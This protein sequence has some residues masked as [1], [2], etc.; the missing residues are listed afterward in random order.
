MRE[1][2][3]EWKL[4]FIATWVGGLLAHAYRFFNF[5][6]T[7]DTLYS[8]LGTGST[9]HSGRWFLDWASRLSTDYELTWVI[10]VLSLLYISIA[11]I[12]IIELLEIKSKSAIVLTSVLIVTFPTVT[13]TF[14]Y[15]FTAD[16][17]MMAFMLAVAGVYLTEKY[18]YGFIPG[19]L[20]VCLSMSAYQAY[21]SVALVLA[22]VVCIKRVLMDGFTFVQAFLREYRQAVTLAGGAVLNLILT[23]VINAYLEI[24]LV[25]YQG[26]NDVHILTIEDNLKAVGTSWNSFKWFFLIGEWADES[27]YSRFNQLAVLLLLVFTVWFV[28]KNKVYKRPVALCCVV[29]AYLCMPMLMYIILFTSIW[30]VYHTLMVMSLCF[31]YVFLLFLSE[32]FDT[33]RKPG[34]WMRYLTT[35]VL[36]AVCYVN[37]LNA[38]YAYYQM[39]ISYEK[40]YAVATDVLNRVEETEGFDGTQ[41][42]AI[43]G[44]YYAY[45]EAVPLGTPE[46]IGVSNNIVLAGQDHFVNM[47][48]FIFGRIYTGADDTETWEVRQTEEY[49]AMNVYPYAGCVEMINDI[50]VVKLSEE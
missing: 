8:F 20:C 45:I 35:F 19:M 48:K 6:P 22:A 29:A 33:E 3:S 21:L 31:V 30:V 26:I 10:A 38:N 2:K 32:Y 12:M 5:L 7:G 25:S 27:W 46:I 1:I 9:Y 14:A 16:G 47:W 39:N 37:I 43:C 44:D 36:S 40:S 50:V 11:V 28:I 15:M 17:Y 4:A 34:K 49:E 24:E 41:K 13:A 18:K 23:K 42:I